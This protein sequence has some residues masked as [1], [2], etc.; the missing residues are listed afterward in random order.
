MTVPDLRRRVAL[1]LVT[2]VAALAP[3][4]AYADPAPNCS[5]PESPACAEPSGDAA[6]STPGTPATP[7]QKAGATGQKPGAT[8]QKPTATPPP[9]VTAGDGSSFFDDV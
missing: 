7:D 4:S 5:P 1:A 6:P 9:P 3:A 8:D 2:L